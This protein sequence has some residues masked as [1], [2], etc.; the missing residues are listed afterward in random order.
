MKIKATEVGELMFWIYDLITLQWIIHTVYVLLTRNMLSRHKLVF[1]KYSHSILYLT[2][3]QIEPE[4]MYLFLW[5][6]HITEYTGFHL[7][8]SDEKP[9]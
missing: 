4:L 8:K 9:K 7:I 1:F 5:T 2:A 6:Q 3:K